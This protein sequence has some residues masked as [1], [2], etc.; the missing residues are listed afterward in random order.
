VNAETTRPFDRDYA[1]LPTRVKD[2]V[3]KQL[4]LL[5]SNPRHPSLHLKRIRGTDGLW[6]ARITRSY[7]VTL[8]I[9]GETYILRRVE[10][11]DVLQER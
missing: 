3:D 11:H 2:Q 5:L 8:E 1:R 10:T 6:E 7:R 9:A 4:S